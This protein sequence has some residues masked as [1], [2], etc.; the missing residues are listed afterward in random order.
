MQ[1]RNR[2]A[3]GLNGGRIGSNPG[4]IGG[5]PGG[6]TVAIRPVVVGGVKPQVPRTHARAGCGG[7]EKGF[8]LAASDRRYSVDLAAKRL[9]GI[10]TGG[11]LRRDLASELLISLL[12]VCRYLLDLLGHGRICIS[13]CL[14]F[15]IDCGTVL[16]DAMIR[17]VRSLLRCGGCLRSIDCRLVGHGDPARAT[18]S[19]WGIEA[20][21]GV[22]PEVLR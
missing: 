12:I 11:R 7:L 22:N 19:L 9:H 21:T 1:V 14:R 4:V 10:G 6:A 18:P 3:L 17:P 8:V 5:Y 20:V 13:P 16:G 2:L 15:F